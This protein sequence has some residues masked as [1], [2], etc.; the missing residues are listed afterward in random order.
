MTEVGQTGP[1]ATALAIAGTI[2]KR[3][4]MLPLDISV[5]EET[6]TVGDYHMQMVND[7]FLSPFLLQ[8][9]VFSA[10]D[11]TQRWITSRHSDPFSSVDLVVAVTFV[12][13]AG[14]LPQVAG[15]LAALACPC[16]SARSGDR[17]GRTRGRGVSR[18]PCAGDTF[19]R[20]PAL[21]RSHG[22]RGSRR[23]GERRKAAQG[24][25]RPDSL[26]QAVVEALSCLPPFARLGPLGR[27]EG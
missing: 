18:P 13:T 8:M 19:R 23:P 3:A 20:R 27:I 1:C 6:K 21:A 22:G 15:S 5:G 10:I 7:R 9:A 16:L 11:A 26:S 14:L 17:L 2:G 25:A 12:E 4:A 24:A